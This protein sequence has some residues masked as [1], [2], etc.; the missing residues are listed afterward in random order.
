METIGSYLYLS[1]KDAVRAYNMFNLE[2]YSAC[3][4]FCEQSVEKS[5]KAFIEIKGSVSD[6]GLMSIHKPRRLYERCCELGLAE[7][8]TGLALVMAKLADYYY[9]TNYPG[10]SYFELTKEE[11]EEALTAM[12]RVNLLVRQALDKEA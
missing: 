9:D 8:D 7:A 3:G 11:A 12:D 4:R 6:I 5:L 1:K 2:D 10:D